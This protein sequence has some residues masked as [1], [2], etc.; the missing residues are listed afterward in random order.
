MCKCKI[1]SIV[2]MKCSKRRIQRDPTQTLASA[3]P[4]SKASK[5]A[6]DTEQ[7]GATSFPQKKVASKG[8]TGFQSN[9]FIWEKIPLLPMLM[10]TW[11]CPPSHCTAPLA[12]PPT[13]QPLMLPPQ[14]KPLHGFSHVRSCGVARD[15][16]LAKRHCL[17]QELCKNTFPSLAVR[18]C[19]SI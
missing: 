6:C 9:N 7:T 8:Q 10:R 15:Q 16:H 3:T 5:A 13:S 11:C 2:H 12:L 18:I 19:A 17:E 1:K 4:P 14:N